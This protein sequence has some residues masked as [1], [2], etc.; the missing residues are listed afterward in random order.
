MCTL[1][2]GVVRR[3]ILPECDPR[4]TSKPMP[5]PHFKLDRRTNTRR[6]F[7]QMGLGALGGAGVFSMS[8]S[9]F[10]EPREAGLPQRRFG[11]NGPVLP[12]L[13]FG[14][15]ALVTRWGS[16]LSIA[17]RVELVQ[18]AFQRGIRYFDT[19]GNYDESQ[20][21]LGKALRGVRKDVFLVTK[22]EATDPAK[23]R[24]A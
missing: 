13:G 7:M 9:G 8:A 23:V 22:V 17:Q 5:I 14:G 24:P 15:A 3:R 19:A 18:Y 20:A 2:E 16:P 1:Q 10:A 6:R 21:I 4:P 11:K 12:I